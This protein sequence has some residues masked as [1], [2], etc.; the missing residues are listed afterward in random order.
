MKKNS[1]C[2]I[3]H[4]FNEI[5]NWNCSANQ[6]KEKNS[7]QICTL[8]C[9]LVYFI[10]D[11]NQMLLTSELHQFILM[12]SFPKVIRLYF[13]SRPTFDDVT[14]DLTIIHQ[15]CVYLFL[16]LSIYSFD[17]LSHSRSNSKFLLNKKVHPKL[18]A[19][20]FEYFIFRYR[21]FFFLVLIFSCCSSNHRMWNQVCK[22]ERDSLDAH[23]F[24]FEYINK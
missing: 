24:R 11:H 15:V 19:H 8:A 22:V 2:Y 10:F 9:L 16:F 17:K 6:M 3:F 23:G 18:C 12:I 5:W 14:L 7:R 20:S 4:K 21:F 1:N 13:I